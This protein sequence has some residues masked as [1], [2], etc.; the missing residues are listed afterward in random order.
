MIVARQNKGIEVVGVDVAG[1]ADDDH[2][3]SVAGKAYQRLSYGG[4]VQAESM[5][6]SAT[7]AHEHEHLT[8]G[9]RSDDPGG[10]MKVVAV[11][12]PGVEVACVSCTLYLE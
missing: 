3:R 5:D 1:T 4:G 2:I 9:L 6:A 12:A 8:L 10:K 7:C 11:V